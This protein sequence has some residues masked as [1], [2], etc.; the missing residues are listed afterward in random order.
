MITDPA[1]LLAWLRAFV[2][3]Q[4]IEMPVYRATLRA[5]W[6][7]A[8]GASAVTHPVVWFFFFHPDF[9]L[10]DYDTRVVLAESFAVLA[11]TAWFTGLRGPW[12]AFGA[13][14]LANG[15]SA[16]LGMLTRRLWGVP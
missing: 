11:E 14:L 9:P 5:P 1:Y 4:A 10:H 12:R 8:F 3:T 7:R 2:F 6:V 13:S 16:G 15:A